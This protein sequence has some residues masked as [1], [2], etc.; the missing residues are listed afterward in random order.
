MINNGGV[1]FGS[2]VSYIVTPSAVIWGIVLLAEP[3]TVTISVSL[4]LIMAG[5]ALIKPRPRKK[6]PETLVP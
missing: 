2:Q 4:V 5:L 6:V 3:L 1:V